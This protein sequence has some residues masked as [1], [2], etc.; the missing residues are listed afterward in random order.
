MLTLHLNLIYHGIRPCAPLTYEL[1]AYFRADQPLPQPT[2]DTPPCSYADLAATLIDV[3][4]LPTH[5]GSA[6]SLTV[7]RPQLRIS[8]RRALLRQRIRPG[9][10]AR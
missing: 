1:V 10:V 2:G 4:A 6:I 3:A 5:C 9:S 8:G 7:E